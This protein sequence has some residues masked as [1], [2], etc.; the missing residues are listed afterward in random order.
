MAS[1]VT[2]ASSTTFDLSI[3]GKREMLDATLTTQYLAPIDVA[4]LTH[5]RLSNK[6]FG[7]E[8]ASILAPKLM[9]MKKLQVA[10]LSDIIAG[11]MT[12]VGLS[13]LNTISKALQQCPTLTEVDLSEN[14]L[15]PRGVAA[16][17]PLLSSVESLKKLTFNN[18]G[19]SKEA[20]N[21]IR[22]LLLFR[23]P[24]SPTVLE[25]LHFW[26]NMSGDGGATAISSVILQSP[27]LSDFR[28]SSTR[29]GSEGGA[30]LVK[31]LST[32]TNL[33]KIDLADNTFGSGVAPLLGP[34]ISNNRNLMHLNLSD[35]SLDNEGVEE[36]MKHLSTT[37]ERK[38]LT[39][40]DLSFNGVVD[41]YEVLKYFPAL[42]AR[43][44]L[45]TFNFEENEIGSR[46]AL[47]IVNGL[48]QIENVVNFNLNLKMCDIHDKGALE[49]AKCFVAFSKGVL[50][51]NGNVMS[52]S[53]I[54]EINKLIG[55]N[56]NL[57]LGSWSDNDEVGSDEEE[58]DDDTVYRANDL[59]EEQDLSNTGVVS[60]SSS[61]SS[62][63]S[64]GNGSV[65]AL[66]S[67][68]GEMKIHV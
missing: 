26:N 20:M 53:A 12:D 19:L 45:E 23:G 56:A 1:I 31:A 9:E 25:K 57:G 59:K 39:F 63:S 41:G 8:A 61:S 2:D 6:S 58:E 40:L 32:R 62:S 17:R 21:E 34:L 15:G 4:K 24:D 50:D 60:G 49:L 42:V 66:S 22:D 5:I 16:C 14:A 30:D 10:D 29:C 54:A 13:V 36:V 27:D 7:N 3:D 55:E 38:C 33:Q 46:G 51:L 37:G 44:S 65:D 48:K 68:V 43:T 67:A 35:L 47:R 11:R 28:L 52:L 18:D 64:N